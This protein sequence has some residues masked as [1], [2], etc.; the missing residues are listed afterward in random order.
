[1]NV[2]CKLE[3]IPAVPF[4]PSHKMF[5]L[6]K[7]K[8][9]CNRNDGYSW[10]QATTVIKCSQLDVELLKGLAQ[11]II[12]K[13]K[14]T[15]MDSYTLFIKWWRVSLNYFRQSIYLKCL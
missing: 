11:G 15:S 3:E 13:S 6:G 5:T 1:M 8:D 2:S 12:S 14:Q 4:T 9:S 10:H 7:Y